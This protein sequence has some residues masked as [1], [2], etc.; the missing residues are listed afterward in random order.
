MDFLA[1]G[2]RVVESDRVV[3]DHSRSF[4]LLIF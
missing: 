1:E 3:I 2:I 4:Q